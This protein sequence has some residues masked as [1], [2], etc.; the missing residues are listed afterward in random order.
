MTILK[1][2]MFP[3]LDKNLAII[4]I[5]EKGYMTLELRYIISF[6]FTLLSFL[7]HYVIL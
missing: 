3:G 5:A 6:K 1:P 2:G 4:G 7:I